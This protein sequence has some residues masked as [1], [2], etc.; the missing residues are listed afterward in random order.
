MLQRAHTNKQYDRKLRLLKDMILLMGYHAQ[1]MI[2]DSIRALTE[3]RSSI[4]R[5]VILRDET[6]DQ[7]EVDVDRLCHEIFALQHPLAGD[8][9]IVTTAF[10]IVR[11]IERIGDIAVNIAERVNELLLEPRVEWVSALQIM[12]QLVQRNLSLSLDALVSSD[13]SAALKVIEGDQEID[14]LNEQIFRE[15]LIYMMEDPNNVPRC[16]KLIFIAKHLERVGD[17]ATNIAEM[18]LFM[19]R[20]EGT[21]RSHLAN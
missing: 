18:I 13:D 5:E 10:K 11:D 4:A 2:A 7:L 14:D 6:L 1:Q 20:G 21:R 3:G 12:A 9:R 17:H 19:I 8:L 15:L 16:L